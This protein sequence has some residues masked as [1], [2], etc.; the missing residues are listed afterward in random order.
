MKVNEDVAVG[1][2]IAS[3]Q[4]SDADEDGEQD[5]RFEVDWETDIHDWFTVE[6]DSSNPKIGKVVVKNPLDREMVT[7]ED[8][9]AVYSFKVL[10]I[11]RPSNIEQ[12]R[13]QVKI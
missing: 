11:D 2:V 3:V 5:I 12:P 4:A 1:Y 9:S 6:P 8:I 13:L 7:T 10:A